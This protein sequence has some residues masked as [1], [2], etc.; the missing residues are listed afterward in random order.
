MA[1]LVWYLGIAFWEMVFIY[2]IEKSVFA[3]ILSDNQKQFL[4]SL[5][6]QCTFSILFQ[7]YFIVFGLHTVLRK[8]VFYICVIFILTLKHPIGDIMCAGPKEKEVV[9]T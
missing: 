2:W 1:I 7:G 5:R 6:V 3:K 9:I 4:F 8:I